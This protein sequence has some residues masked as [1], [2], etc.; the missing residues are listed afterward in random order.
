[1]APKYLEAF[2]NDETQPEDF[3]QDGRAIRAG[4]DARKEILGKSRSRFWPAPRP[5]GNAGPQSHGSR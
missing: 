2:A 1:M 5:L 4:A 3:R